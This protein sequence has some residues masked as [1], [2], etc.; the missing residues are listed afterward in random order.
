M[1]EQHSEYVAELNY[2]IQAIRSLNI[3]PNLQYV[4]DPDGV[5]QV[6]NALVLGLQVQSQF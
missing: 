5:R 1:P 3:M 2:G 4:K 6:K